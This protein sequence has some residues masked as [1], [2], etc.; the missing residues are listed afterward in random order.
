MNRIASIMHLNWSTIEND[1]TIFLNK[2]GININFSKLNISSIE[3]Q[4]AIKNINQ[5]RLKNNPGKITDGLIEKAYK[6]NNY[7]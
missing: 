2:I 5:E 6:F 4:N 7:V 3:F 1:I